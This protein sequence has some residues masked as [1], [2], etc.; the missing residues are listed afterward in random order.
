MAPFP[1][2]NRAHGPRDVGTHP[3]NNRGPS[4]RGGADEAYEA[5]W[6]KAA[7]AQLSNPNTG[8]DFSAYENIPVSTDPSDVCRPAETFED[9]RLEVEILDVLKQRRY[10]H[11]TPIQ[12]HSIPIVQKGMD[13]IAVAQTGPMAGPIALILAPTRELVIQIQDEAR[14]FVHHTWLRPVAIYGGASK[15]PQIRELERGVDLLV[16]TPGRI[17]DIMSMG[18]LHV[19]DVKYLVL[20]E[21]DRMLDM[22]FEE[23][24]RHIVDQE[25]MLPPGDRI[26]L[27]FSATFP[28]S[29]RKL[30]A[31]FTTPDAV[32]LNVGRV[33]STSAL[34]DQH[35]ENVSGWGAKWDLLNDTLDLA[36]NNNQ[37]ARVLVFCATKKD[38]QEVADRLFDSGLRAACIHG[39]KDQ[40]Q[41]ERALAGFKAGKAP[42][43]VATDVAARGLD[44]PHVS[45]VV[46]FDMPNDVEDY[47]HRIGRTGRAGEKGLAVSFFSEARDGKLAKGLV[48]LVQDAKQ[49]VPE[50]LQAAAAHFRPDG[51]SISRGRARPDAWWKDPDRGRGASRGPGGRDVSRGRDQ[52]RGPPQGFRD[53]VKPAGRGGFGGGDGGRGGYGGRGG[54][55][56]GG[57]GGGFDGGRGGGRGGDDRGFSR[58]RDSDSMG[59]DGGGG[60]GGRGGGGFGGRGGGGFGGR[61]RDDDRHGR[62]PSRGRF[63]GPGRAGPP[64]VSHGPPRGRVGSCCGAQQDEC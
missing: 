32:F 63:E 42:V 59:R 31:D 62:A 19:E 16:A 21:A 3:G 61:G 56:G 39:D 20:D 1:S 33:G 47:V 54:G 57:R 12:R 53:Q 34:I 28:K 45:L 24:V 27:M 40:Q 23:Q 36:L 8:I 35:F 18:K 50:F 55:F 10:E 5:N 22:G 4:S 26:T 6:R 48:E 51:R 29:V 41:R 46:N 14:K 37:Q 2:N 25:G 64:P 15:G 17:I 44:V 7:A 11:P 9:M 60:R 38:T 13:L 58:N 30:A 52:S 43:L 49:T